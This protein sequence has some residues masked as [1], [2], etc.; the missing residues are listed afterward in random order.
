MVNVIEAL[1]AGTRFHRAGQLAEAERIYRQVLAVDPN[2]AQALHQLGML[3]LQCRQFQQAAEL[4]ERALKADRSQLAY[5]VN[6]SEAYRHLGR[7]SEAVEQLQTV[8]KAQPDAVELQVK[9]GSL[10]HSAGQLAEA[11]A[12]LHDALRRRPDDVAARSELGLVLQKQ[13]KPA[14]AEACFRRVLRVAP[15]L[16]DAH[17]NLGSALQLQKRLP[18]AAESYRAAIKLDPR[19]ALAHFNLAAVALEQ[20]ETDEAIVHY[21][22]GLAVKPDDA[23]AH[24]HLAAVYE[25]LK[26]YDDA[27]A[28][29][30]AQ[31]AADPKSTAARI[32]LG[33]LREMQGKLAE[34]ESLLR[35]AVEIDPK[36]LSALNSLGTVLKK[37]FKSDE[38]IAVYEAA[39]AIDPRHAG[40]LNN[41]GL[42]YCDIGVRDEAVDYFRRA[43]EADGRM[44]YAYGNLAVALQS[45]GKMDEA[46]AAYR[47][48]IELA[49]DD[50]SLHSNLLYAVNFNPSFDPDTIFA[51]HVAW[52]KRHADPLTERAAAHTNPRDP[53]RRLRL[54]YVSPFFRFH[55]MNFF[56]EPILR[57]HDHRQFEIFLYTDLIY[58]DDATQRIRGYADHWRPT[59]GLTDEQAAQLVRRDQIDILVDLPG[60]LGGNRMI[61]FAHKPAP[62]Q[63]TYIGYQNTTGMRA[64]DY[65]LTDA[66]ADPP[67]E[68]DRWHTERLARL[69]RSFFCYEPAAT[70]PPVV[71]PPALANGHV[72]FGSFNNFSKVTPDVLATW[73][74]IMARVPRSRLIILGQKADSLRRYLAEIFARDGVSDDRLELV[75]RKPHAE[76]LE[77]I[78]RS[79]LALDPFPFNGHTTTLDALWQGVCTVTLS[80][81]TYVSRF[82]GSGLA[83]LGLQDFIARSPAQY[84]EI[85]VGMASN[86]ERLAE[87][88]RTMRKRML[89]SPLLDFE[90]FTR[91]LEAEYRRMWVRWCEEHPQ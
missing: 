81:N 49:P 82:G 65:R 35:Q 8:L 46:M 72:T 4:I 56:I 45:L 61:L 69:P 80:G 75:D 19:M 68:T 26:R 79:D 48:S 73:A 57:C 16:A 20:G 24:G 90:G 41:L 59:V 86:L 1:A 50:A 29:Y 10:L 13:D 64:M 77:L 78:A 37:A 7:T 27:E 55:A 30:Q 88:R 17:F 76:Y 42:A 66:Y 83:T 58:A 54:G 67:G 15:E 9:L 53:H 22:A 91:N 33:Q 18:E 23:E 31:L 28:S 14:E 34:A 21:K 6:L 39:L 63:V 12:A 47:K 40:T 71:E 36:S 51:E 5:R 3:G 44:V 84:L 38:A 60:H 52:G 2:N 85:A 11:V 62:V 43:I 74:K 32:G 87:L 25:S 89:D 70:A